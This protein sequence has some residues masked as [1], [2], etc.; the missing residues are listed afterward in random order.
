MPRA[1]T[2]HA[3]KTLR[4]PTVAPDDVAAIA[5]K[6]DARYSSMVWLGAV[7]GLSF[8]SVGA[9]CHTL[10]RAALNAGSDSVSFV[11]FT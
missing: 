4:R 5:E 1:S 10:S 8:W 3:W 7:L 6:I 11:E 9:H 2:C